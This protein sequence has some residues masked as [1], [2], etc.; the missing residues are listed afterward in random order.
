MRV[1][2]AGTTRAVFHHFRIRDYFLNDQ[3]L[4]TPHL[5]FLYFILHINHITILV[6]SPPQIMLFAVDFHE[7]FINEE[8]ITEASVL[9]FQSACINRSEFDTPKT[10][11][12]PGDSDATFSEEI[13]YIAKA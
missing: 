2:T 8:G 4:S 9:P 11:C 5:Y 3:L 1:L 12:F 7:D 13:F 6:N 10:D